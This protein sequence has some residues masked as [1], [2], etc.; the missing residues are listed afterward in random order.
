VK[1][2]AGAPHP[3]VL[4]RLLHGFRPASSLDVEGVIRLPARERLGSGLALVEEDSGGVP[5]RE[6]LAEGPLA[7]AR[8]LDVAVRV[9]SIFGRIHTRDVVHK[10]VNP[11]VPA[12]RER[13]RRM[14]RLG[15]VRRVL[16]H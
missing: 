2:A 11:N 10:D 9:T 12:M 6:V 14:R 16:R 1:V 7:P 5:L 3:A 15:R 8:F 4:A 13:S